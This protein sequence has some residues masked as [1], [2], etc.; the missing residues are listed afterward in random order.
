MAAPNPRAEWDTPELLRTRRYTIDFAKNYREGRAREWKLPSER[1]LA[2]IE[3][4]KPGLW[5]GLVVPALKVDGRWPRVPLVP[6]V[7][8]PNRHADNPVPPA[9]TIA[10]VEAPLRDVFIPALRRDY[11][12]EYKRALGWGGMGVVTAFEVRDGHGLRVRDVAVKISIAADPELV[13]ERDNHVF[14]ARARH[15]VQMVRLEDVNKSAE[16]S[17]SSDGR[18]WFNPGGR[19]KRRRGRDSP[20]GAGLLSAAGYRRLR[21]Y[22]ASVLVSPFKRRRVDEGEP[23]PI[24]AGRALPGPGNPGMAFAGPREQQE[25]MAYR[26]PSDSSTAPPDPTT[27][28]GG[29]YEKSVEM[30]DYFPPP[31]VDM[32]PLPPQVRGLPRQQ[33]PQ[34]PPAFM[35]PPRAGPTDEPIDD[36]VLIL[37]MLSRGNLEG[38]IAKMAVTQK[39]FPNRILWLFF[40][41]LFKGV[42][43]MDHPPLF[44]DDFDDT[45]GPDGPLEEERVPSKKNPRLQPSPDFV[46]FDLDPL[47]ILVGDFDTIF[48]G[49]HNFTPILKIG[50]LGLGEKTDKLKQDPIGI[51][52]SRGKG[53]PGLGLLSPEQFSEEWD[54]IGST[55]ALETKF[56]PK[57][58]GQ[59]SW[60]TNLFQVGLVRPCH[61]LPT[62]PSTPSSPLP[63]P[64]FHLANLTT[65]FTFPDHVRPHHH[66]PAPLPPLP[67]D[68]VPVQPPH[69]P[70]PQPRH[71]HRALELR[72]L[73][74]QRPLRRR[75]PRPARDGRPLPLRRPRRPPRPRRPLEA[76]PVKGQGPLARRPVRPR[77]ARLDPRLL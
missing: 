25:Q 9:E 33:P 35:G 49:G 45:G 28:A 47:N 77:H 30:M 54:Y 67:R 73:A 41:C 22:F 46:H 15:V 27:G 13:R 76:D 34:K 59:Y 63:Y 55:P 48:K 7:P 58:A 51:W 20:D 14:L 17:S 42:V 38:W 2:L 56:K 29:G 70:R 10:K 3:S 16:S 62:H 65:S 72:H 36:R 31:T 18:S 43:A 12:M 4:P 37:E 74:A 24:V 39:F 40:E 68:R 53:K 6:H 11:N 5:P 8:D 52:R 69:R 60:K 75:R 26:V 64:L 44:Y 71:R 50:D 32:M 66:L 21:N 1:R 23:N 57:I 61:F 19:R